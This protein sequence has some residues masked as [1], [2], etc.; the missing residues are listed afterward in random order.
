ASSNSGGGSR[1]VSLASRLFFASAYVRAGSLSGSDTPVGS[2]T[3]RAPSRPG[4]PG[5][6]RWERS[7]VRAPGPYPLS[8]PSC[9]QRQA[10][11]RAPAC[12]AILTLCDGIVG[13][14]DESP[15][16]NESAGVLAAGIYQGTGPDTALAPLPRWNHAPLEQAVIGRRL[17]DLRD[18]TLRSELD[19]PD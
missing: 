12:A 6:A 15:G 2:G 16:D 7:L 1:P 4:R 5:T 19:T 14:R 3:P 8:R 11:A 9:P 10:M 17:L 18:G 13:T